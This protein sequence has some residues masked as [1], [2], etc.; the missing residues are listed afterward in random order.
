[1]LKRSIE[2]DL[3]V[4]SVSTK[5][6]SIFN[7]GTIAARRQ[8]SRRL[9]D[10]VALSRGAFA[11]SRL[12]GHEAL[13][14]QLMLLLDLEPGLSLKECAAKLSATQPNVSASVKELVRMG[15][16]DR[17]QSSGDKRRHELQLTD[18]GQ[19]AITEFFRKLP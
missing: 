5:E 4:L 7:G 17:K 9:L 3:Y 14:M 2:S 1:M 11:P 15:F 12:S 10:A 16:L 6:N 13:G 19:I 8:A 18:S